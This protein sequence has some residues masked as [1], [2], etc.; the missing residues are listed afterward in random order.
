MTG[1]AHESRFLPDLTTAF[2]AINVE[3]D[4]VTAECVAFPSISFPLPPI[5]LTPELVLA[6]TERAQLASVVGR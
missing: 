5:T 4:I 1:A 2:K 6:V 3:E